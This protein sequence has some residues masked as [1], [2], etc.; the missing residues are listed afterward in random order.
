MHAYK[1]KWKD[2]WEFSIVTEHTYHLQTVEK[3]NRNLTSQFIATEMYGMIVDNLSYEPKFIIRHIKE[4]YKYTISYKKV[5]IAKQKVLERRFGT[6]E[7][8]YDNL[9]RMLATICNRNNV[10]R[11]STR[12]TL[13][14]V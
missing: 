11:F 5:W 2:Y 1:G 13:S 9:H 7:A 4:K 6:Y 8:A 12:G 14:K 3:Y 10:L